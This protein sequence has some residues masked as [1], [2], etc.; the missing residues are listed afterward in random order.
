M[1]EAS[2]TLDRRTTNSRSVLFG[3]IRTKGANTIAKAIGI[4]PST[5]SE[6]WQEHHERIC[7]FLTAAD[8][9]PVPIVW[10]CVE[11]DEYR[12]MRRTTIEKLQQDE[13]AEVGVAKP[14]EWDGE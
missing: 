1:A 14:L 6:W 7:L 4:A 5:F 8:L 3:A 9:K 2:P 10:K 11:P 12:Y 13:R